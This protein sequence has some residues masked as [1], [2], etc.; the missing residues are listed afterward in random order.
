MRLWHQELLEKIPRQ[1]LLGQHRECCALSGCSKSHQMISYE[2]RRQL[3]FPLLI[4]KAQAPVQL[5]TNWKEC[6]EIKETQRT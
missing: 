5:R 2:S 3:V 4:G 6:A 1:Q